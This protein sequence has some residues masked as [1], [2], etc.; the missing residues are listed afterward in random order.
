[1]E[2]IK[3]SMLGGKNDDKDQNME[4]VRGTRKT[5]RGIRAVS[6]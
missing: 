3:A 6:I 5:I 4:E 1:M 2:G